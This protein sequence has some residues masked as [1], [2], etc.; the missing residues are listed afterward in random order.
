MRK[1]IHEAPVPP[2]R[3][4]PDAE[5]TETA[6]KLILRALAKKPADRQQSMDELR[7]ELQLCFGSVAYKRDAQKFG[8]DP[9]RLDGN[10]WAQ[11]SAPLP[12]MPPP[13][14]RRRTQPGAGLSAIPPVG[15]ADPVPVK[16]ASPAPPPPLPPGATS[17]KPGTP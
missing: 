13:A 14:P 5:I 15:A 6:E 11:G 7:A 4:R 2:R 17:K 16:P 9:V 3:A 1:H 12:G 8:I 10:Q